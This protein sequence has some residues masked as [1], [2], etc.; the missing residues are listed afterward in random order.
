M[1]GALARKL[2][3]A[4]GTG[5]LGLLVAA[6]TVPVL[7]QSPEPAP[8]ASGSAGTALPGDPTHGQQ[9]YNQTCT[10]CHGASLEGGVG[11]KLSPLAK[12]PGS[13]D[14]KKV[15]EP[16]VVQYMITTITV[17]KQ[18]SGQV[19][20]PKGGNA[21]L[22]DQDIKDI[23]AYIIQENLNPGQQALGPVE[24]ARSNVLWVTIG[25]GVMVLLT[26]F[27]ARYNMRWIAYRAQKGRE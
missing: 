4:F 20:P 11:P 25:V 22:S 8:S 13:P 19:M 2:A 16:Q 26:W 17:G 5:F 3:V 24:L 10:A 12:I 6:G 9:L 14:Y 21:S 1:P 27:L 18:D 15:N 23:V 7:A